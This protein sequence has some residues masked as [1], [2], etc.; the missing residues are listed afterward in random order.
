MDVPI[1]GRRGAVAPGGRRTTHGR[2]QGERRDT[3][4]DAAL[5][6]GTA[7]QGETAGKPE[8]AGDGRE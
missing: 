2:R 8:Q 6:M 4:R 1:L 5:R 3:R 7:G